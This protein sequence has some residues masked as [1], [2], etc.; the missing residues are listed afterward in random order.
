MEPDPGRGFSIFLPLLVQVHRRAGFQLH[1][2]RAELGLET[3]QYTGNFWSEV[4]CC[5][6][7]LGAFGCLFQKNH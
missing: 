6:S 7:S 5:C 2:T 1:C 4:S 3:V